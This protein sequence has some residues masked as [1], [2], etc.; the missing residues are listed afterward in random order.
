MPRMGF[1]SSFAGETCSNPCG[2]TS[3]EED[4]CG[5]YLTKT[6][7]GTGENTGRV[8]TTTFPTDPNGCGNN[9]PEA[10]SE[11][12][13]GYSLTQSLK[14]DYTYPC[15]SASF[16]VTLNDSFSWQG[17][18]SAPLVGDGT[19][20][21][22]ECSGSFSVS[23]TLDGENVQVTGTAGVFD[24]DCQFQISKS[25][26][27]N[28]FPEY[29]GLG[30]IGFGIFDF[31]GACAGQDTVFTETITRSPEELPAEG[32]INP[33]FGDKNSG[34]Q[35]WCGDPIEPVPELASEDQW[36]I[37]TSRNVSISGGSSK[38]GN[39]KSKETANFK[40]VHEPTVS[41]YLKVWFKKTTTSFGLS[42]PNDCGPFYNDETSQES[43]IETYEW[44]GTNVGGGLCIEPHVEFT[45]S[46]LIYG[47]EKTL[48]ANPADGT[49]EFIKYEILKWSILENY[50]PND[51]DEFGNQGCKPNGT[52]TTDC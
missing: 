23:I 17:S 6:T 41:C 26:D 30:Q 20:E 31:G 43:A 33:S 19:T 13:G 45:P 8:Q 49:S 34:C 2:D 24:G 9:C 15:G 10:N 4:P 22:T 32:E 40:F 16:E 46:Q 5:Y 14:T 3:N 51:P 50:E 44:S 29:A 48:T 7:N 25:G 37:L 1:V 35:G 38:Y 47:S 28:P 36:F 18:C 27:E 21:I 42:T 52:P 39:I 11:C 12:S